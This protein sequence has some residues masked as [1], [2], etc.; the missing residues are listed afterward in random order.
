VLAIV[1]R[2]IIPAATRYR[3]FLVSEYI[4]RPGKYCARCP[5]SWLGLLSGSGFALHHR[6][7]RCESVHELGIQQMAAIEA[8]ARPIASG[9]SAR[10]IFPPCMKDS[11]RQL[12]HLPGS[13]GSDQGSGGPGCSSQGGDAEVVRRLP[14]NVIVDPCLPF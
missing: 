9:A 7:S 4:P 10:Q 12:V 5:P 2:E 8:A 3:D 14:G 6:K 11:G 1:G 13:P